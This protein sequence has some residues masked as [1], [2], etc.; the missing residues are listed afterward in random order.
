MH[1]I[2]DSRITVFAAVARHMSFTNAA[3]ALQITQPAVSFQIRSLETELGT[4]VFKRSVSGLELTEVGKVLL[5]HV[6]PLRQ[7]AQRIDNDITHASGVVQGSLGV[8]VSL[9]IGTYVLP[10]IIGRFIRRHGDCAVETLIGNSTTILD[11]VA[12]E[13]VD[14]A[15]L[16]DPVQ[17]RDVVI[18]PF[19]EDEIVLIVPPRHP[20]AG[21]GSVTLP[22]LS[23]EP[24]IMREKGSGTR[25]MLEA[26]LKKVGLS[27]KDLNVVATI[28]GF[29]AVKGTVMQG[30]G[31]S[32]APNI[33]VRSEVR[34]GRLAIV[35]WPDLPMKRNFNL[36]YSKRAPM[37]E[38]VTRFLDCAREVARES[39]WSPA[40]SLP[41][42]D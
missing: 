40:A 16:S 20:W 2:L 25:K 21:R 31:V 34:D 3:A 32:V 10:M 18:E 17:R 27:A 8:A 41:A 22:E 19:L 33:G 12:D 28:G 39:L 23:K 13:T 6:E 38:R 15:I 26:N 30:I 1:W 7:H 42:G 29:E 9:A 14:V 11:Y 36:V 5:A 35:P 24:F 4:R 37:P